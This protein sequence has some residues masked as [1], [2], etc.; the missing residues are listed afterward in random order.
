MK[1][2][3]IIA[4]A[5]LLLAGTA[6]AQKIGYGIYAGVNFT[7]AK[8][9]YSNM[10]NLPI[11]EGGANF[12]YGVHVN[13]P[14]IKKLEVETGLQKVTTGY[15]FDASRNGVP[16][17]HYTKIQNVSLPVTLLYNIPIDLSDFEVRDNMKDTDFMF[18]IGAG[19]F[20]Q[21]ALSGK[22]TD[23]DGNS[24]SA[25]FSNAKRLDMGPRLMMKFTLY[26]K[27]EVFI[28]KEWGAVNT[29][30]NGSG[31]LRLNSLQ[32]GFGYRIK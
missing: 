24:Q 11:T 15:S 30:K 20:G 22:I 31:Y 32:M 25:K 13:L 21:Y 28:A 18:G 29:I 23:E 10:Y 7:G 6:Q 19:L 8:T 12:T 2:G 17:S 27:F 9:D 3:T 14:L 4:A 1:K 5:M 16:F 26:Q